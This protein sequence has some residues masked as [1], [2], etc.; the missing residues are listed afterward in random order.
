LIKSIGDHRGLRRLFR[1]RAKVDSADKYGRTPL[2]YAVWNGHV[3]VVKRLLR[4]GAC[5]DLADSIGGTALSYALCSGHDDLLK[6]LFKKGTKADLKD[7]TIMALLFSAAEKSH[8]AVV[9]LLLETSKAN[10]DMKDMDGR[11]PLTCAVEGG[12]VAIVQHLLAN[13]VEMDYKYKMVSNR[14]PQC[15]SAS[16]CPRVSTN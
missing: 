15:V 1:R 7:D 6:L 8:E 2:V 10:P 9:K 16:I 14:H 13:E 5:I 11:T 12:S 3:A 4:A